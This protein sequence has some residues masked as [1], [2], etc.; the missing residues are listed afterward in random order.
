MLEATRRGEVR[1]LPENEAEF[2]RVL[3]TAALS[4]VNLRTGAAAHGLTQTELEQQMSVS[5]PS[6]V[7]LLR[8][9]RPVLIEQRSEGSRGAR[10]ALDPGA[11][12]AVGVHIGRAELAVVLADLYGRILP[13]TTPPDYE[14]SAE[15]TLG[16]ADATLDWIARA[17]AQR[18]A[19]VGRSREEVI[20]VGIALG[21]PVDRERGVLRA[22]LD[23]T[24]AGSDWELL[25][26][27]DELPRRLGWED[28]PFLLD[29]DAN[30][31]ALAEYTWGAARPTEGRNYRNVLYVEWSHGI[32]AGLILGGELYRGAGVA[33]ELG[34]AVVSAD[35]P[36]CPQCGHGGCLEALIGWPALARQLE[37]DSLE[38]ALSQ[39]RAGEGRARAA[40][41]AAAEQLAQA[42]G[43]LISVLNPGLV[44][45]GGTVGQLGY[46]VVRP[47][48]LQALKRLTMRPALQ[49]VELAAAT[50]P[51]RA[52]LQGALALVLRAPRHDPDPLLAYLQ[53]SAR[54]LSAQT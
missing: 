21:G 13:V 25:S 35:G 51:T 46:D 50:L 31:S 23:A 2:L 17:I 19:E 20:G 32:G 1:P 16:D 5:R 43:P 37:A 40:F 41:A 11:G 24:G 15:R 38:G 48:L 8:H 53:R 28:V 45:I 33:G 3:R 6:I 14:R 27:R 10:I 4:S 18:L 49:D 34:H 54:S 36:A 42:L 29:N 39:A 44:L 47:T 52:A 30:L 26:V 7:N 9:F 12:V 22:P